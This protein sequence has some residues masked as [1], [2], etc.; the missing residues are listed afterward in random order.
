L[1]CAFFKQTNK[2]N[3]KEWFKHYPNVGF[4]NAVRFMY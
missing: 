1:R 4:I 3:E 2:E